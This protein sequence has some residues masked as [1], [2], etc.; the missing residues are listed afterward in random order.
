MHLTFHTHPTEEAR[1]HVIP[2]GRCGLTARLTLRPPRV[3]SGRGE[4]RTDATAQKH[5]AVRKTTN[6]ET[7]SMPFSIAPQAIRRGLNVN[8][9]RAAPS[10]AAGITGK[11]ERTELGKCCR[12]FVQDA[13]LNVTRFQNA[14]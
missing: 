6:D 10:G 9:A 7:G 12:R 8:D 3:R 13:K 14:L 5:L 1:A 2:R 4:L 11:P